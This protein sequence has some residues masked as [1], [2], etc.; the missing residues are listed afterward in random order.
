MVNHLAERQ[1]ALSLIMFFPGL[2]KS[3]VFSISSLGPSIVSSHTTYYPSLSSS[4]LPQ[5]CTYKDRFKKKQS[6]ETKKE[7]EVSKERDGGRG[8]RELETLT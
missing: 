4:S 7:A 1:R 8:G 5:Y 6:E 3:D 2:K